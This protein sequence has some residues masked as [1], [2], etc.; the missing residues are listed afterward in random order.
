M[1][2][3]DAGPSDYERSEELRSA[4]RAA[5]D[6]A[7][8]LREEFPKTWLKVEKLLKK[9]TLSWIE[10]HDKEDAVREAQEK[11]ERRRRDT[12]RRAKA[13]LSRDEQEALG[14]RYS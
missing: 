14:I 8:V 5:C 3:M 10:D 1:P 7:K 9:S 11:A 6:M 12:V 2:C 4:G 13:K